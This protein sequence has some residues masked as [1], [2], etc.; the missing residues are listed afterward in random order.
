M[1]ISPGHRSL[2]LISSPDLNIDEAAVF[3]IPL[4]EAEAYD[5]RQGQ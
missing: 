4:V 1:C 3:R 5:V 2:I